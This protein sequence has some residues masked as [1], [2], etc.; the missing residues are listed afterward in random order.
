[1]ISQLEPSALTGNF[2][3]SKMPTDVS[4]LSVTGASVTTE[5]QIPK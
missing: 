2:L 4:I 3:E 5:R 1:M